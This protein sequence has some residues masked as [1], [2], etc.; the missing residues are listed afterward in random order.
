MS[1]IFAAKNECVLK[2][3]VSDHVTPFT[4][5]STEVEYFGDLRAGMKLGVP[6]TDHTS[7]NIDTVCWKRES[8]V[9]TTGSMCG[10]LVLQCH[11]DRAIE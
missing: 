10:W 2:E 1:M 11:D 8:G 6:V 7:I 4:A 5:D 3:D 9:E